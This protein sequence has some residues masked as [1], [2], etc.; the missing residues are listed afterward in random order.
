MEGLFLIRNVLP[1]DLRQRILSKLDDSVFVDGKTTAQGMAENVKS[2]E[3]VDLK[4]LPGV[5]DLIMDAIGSHPEFNYL[6]MPKLMSTPL[7]SRYRPGMTYGTHTDNAVMSGG[8]RS[9]VSFTL[10]LSDSESYD[11]GELC[12][13]TSFGEQAV[14]IPAGAML[15]YPTGGL[16]RVAPVKTGARMAIVGWLQSRVRDA[17]KRQIL[18]DLDRSRKAYL[19]NVGHD[20]VADLLFKSTVNLRRM[21]DDG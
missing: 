7:I 18:Y 11:G 20:R 21:W 5:T 13:E 3:Q 1:K 10:M 9:D 15:V 16:H 2:N 8:G 17:A 4:R 12:M 19:K 14:R 6:T